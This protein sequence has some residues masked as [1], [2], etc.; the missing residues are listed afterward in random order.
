MIG[1]IAD[2]QEPHV[3]REFFQL[4]KTPWEFYDPGHRYDVI[5]AAGEEPPE[6]NA[7]LVIIYAGESL[8]FDGGEPSE[9]SPSNRDT[10]ALWNDIQLPIY[11]KSITFRNTDSV[12]VLQNK[13]GQV[14]GYEKKTDHRRIVR[15]GYDLFREVYFLLTKG[16]PPEN[17]LYPTLDYHIAMLR[18]FITETGIPLVEIPPTPAGYKFIACLTHD[19]D[20][21]SIRHHLID[22]SFLGFLYR[23]T[24]GSVI[25]FL[26][27]KIP[28]SN[29]IE[30][31]KAVLSLPLIFSKRYK[32][33]W[34]QF[35]KYLEIEQG[36][37]AT[38]FFIPFKN[39]P[40]QGFHEKKRAY[41]AAKYDVNDVK[42]NIKKIMSHGCEAG[43]HGIDSWHSAEKGRR[44]RE[45]ITT[46][47]MSDKVGIRMHW[48]CMNDETFS[49][50]D[51]AGYDYDSTFGFNETVG[52]KAGTAQAYR[53]IG[54]KRLL[55]LP[56]HIQDTAL[57]NSGRM[58][59]TA[60]NAEHLCNK[61]TGHIVGQTGGV[62][63]VLW[64]QRSIGPERL[65][66]AFY[67]HLIKKLRDENCWFATAQD[68]VDWFRLRR[69]AEFMP[70]G[71]IHI[72]YKPGGNV[73]LPKLVLRTYNS[74]EPIMSNHND[75][76]IPF[77]DKQLK[78]T[79]N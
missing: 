15:I 19:V 65:W 42:E 4:F 53:P 60:H 71:E 48:L 44:E 21:I 66:G 59:M 55:E 58:N 28:F 12:S 26:K 45:R 29:L 17:A 2:K 30:N 43:V 32:D 70:N 35:D 51:Q 18:S 69:S 49:L 25:D 74:D 78:I 47:T 33:P 67:S 22:H 57:F 79:A 61:I 38:F 36:L 75:T 31:L 8:P 73:G 1:V 6:A 77:I 46:I 37:P 20:F 54:V 52:F 68:A 76:S 72:S 9:Q 62:V 41:R 56:I 3:I 27:K 24:V 40:G 23:A 50:L 5:L 34:N 10:F 11:G 7:P 13:T 64:H 39:Q 63:T 16:Q 14:L